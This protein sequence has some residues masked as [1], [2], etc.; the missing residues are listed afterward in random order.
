[1]H[2]DR[3]H[4][5]RRETARRIGLVVA[6]TATIIAVL[7]TVIEALQVRPE[8]NSVEG[9]NVILAIGAAVACTVG[10]SILWL[11][12]GQGVGR[13][14][15]AAGV[16]AAL[17]FAI[18]SL[19]SQFDPYTFVFGQAGRA[20]VQIAEFLSSASL[21]AASL[22]VVVRFPSG[23]RTSRLGTLVEVATVFTLV[24]IAVSTIAPGTFVLLDSVAASG[25]LYAYPLAALD[26]ILR[27]R[28][29][30]AQER[31]QFRWLIASSSISGAL[32]ILM[33]IGGEAMAWA[34]GAWLVS[35]LLP[36]LA[37][38]IAVTRYHL[39][40]IDRIISRTLTYGGVTVGLFALFVAANLVTQWALAPFTGGNAIAVAGSTL[41]AA[42]AFSPLRTRLQAVVDR[43][44]NRGRYDAERTI[45]VFAGRLRDELDL[46]TLAEALQRTTRMAVEPASTALWLR[47]TGPR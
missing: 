24:G 43:R 27:Y 40:E 5:S 17:S 16:V 32:V 20:L 22:I 4:R 30:P 12:P 18:N 39:Y 31:V 21:V 9:F 41:I 1:M 6:P 11:R 35:T 10:A 14:L 28:R 26:V 37:I 19:M 47:D 44:F 45:D 25:M 3:A 34:W 2:G 15:L 33:L 7:V 29:A 42:A 23:H 36:T 13:I 38:G 8:V 46:T